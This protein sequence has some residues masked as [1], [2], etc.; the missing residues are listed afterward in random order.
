L[1]LGSREDVIAEARDNA[2]AAL[3]L[4]GIICGV[5]TQVPPLVPIENVIAMIETLEE[6]H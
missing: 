1:H 5:S 6:Y 3:E 2:E 4:G